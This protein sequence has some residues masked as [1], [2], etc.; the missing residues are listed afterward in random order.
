MPAGFIAVQ[1]VGGNE[2]ALPNPEWTNRNGYGAVVTV[3][4]GGK[5]MLREKRCGEGFSSQ[6]STTLI[7]GLGDQ[8]VAESVAV[9]WPSGKTWS[10][11]NVESGAQLTVF[12]NPTMS[13]NGS[14]FELSEYQPPIESLR[15][16]VAAHHGPFDYQFPELGNDGADLRVMITM[17]TWCESCKRH[18]GT[19]SRLKQK[20][21]NDQ[22]AFYGIPIDPSDTAAKLD[23]YVERNNV[24]Y[25][26][27]DELDEIESKQ[28]ADFINQRFGSDSLPSTIVTNRT[29]QPLAVQF[30]IPT[31]SD[32]RRILRARSGKSFTRELGRC[33]GIVYAWS[34]SAMCVSIG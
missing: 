13:A 9:R 17:A 12:E 5:S 31:V 26:I 3:T 10:T 11:S 32:I 6:N 27:I 28:A 29:G 34:F 23:E 21:E 14:G 20:C 33:R 7:I 22:V 25:R 4:A 16:T 30:G 2:Q 15:E 8:T 1:L 18:L 19:I 24:P